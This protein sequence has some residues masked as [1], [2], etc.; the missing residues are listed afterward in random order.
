MQFSESSLLHRHRHIR[1][2]CMTKIYKAIYVYIVSYDVVE[3]VYR[4]YKE[5][6]GT[7]MT[8]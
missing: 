8:K 5:T 3:M 4:V 2:M 7:T 6:K 1:N